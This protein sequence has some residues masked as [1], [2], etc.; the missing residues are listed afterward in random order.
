LLSFFPNDLLPFVTYEDKNKTSESVVTE[1]YNQNA[2]KYANA[3][4][5]LAAHW[6]GYIVFVYAACT[7]ST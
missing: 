1:W 3:N 6:P 4:K 7:C 2:E 5:D